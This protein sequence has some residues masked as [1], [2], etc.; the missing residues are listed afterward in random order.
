VRRRQLGDR[1]VPV[2]SLGSW[3]TWDRVE[4][5]EA[6]TMIARAAELGCAF[7]DVAH[8]DMGPHAENARTDLIFGE[9]VREAGLAREDWLYCGKLW[10]WDYPRTGFGPQLRTALERVGTGHADFV[11]VGDYFGELDV[12]RVVADV[13]EQIDAGRF[14]AWGVNNWRFA[15]VRAA[16]D[17]ARRRGLVPPSF[18]QLKYSLVRRSM[19]EGEYYAPL[20][21]SGEL[22]LQASDIFEGGLL[23]GNLR[24]DR[25]IGADVGGIREQIAGT[26]PAVRRAAGELGVSPAQLGIAFCLAN[27]AT[28]NVLVGA[29]RLAQLEENAAAV[30]LVDA[31]GAERIRT[32]TEEFSLDRE[33]AADGTW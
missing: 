6:V 32:L 16:V 30:E 12:E 28:A 19:A 22:A 11:V 14:T 1:A 33:V 7:F 23:V 20:F 10:L 15:D 9:A 17:V 31:L 21:A 8:Y 5:G 29:S 25:K 3:N 13:A 18:A 2:L 4:F 27:P 24:P 26:W